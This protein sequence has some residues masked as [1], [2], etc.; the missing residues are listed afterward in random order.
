MR[1]GQVQAHI[2]QTADPQPCP[3][4]LPEGYEDF[5]RPSGDAQECQGGRGNNSWYG[6]GQ[7]NALNAV[8]K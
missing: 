5:T 3:S 7:V 1:P 2:Q 4:E 8:T 6:S